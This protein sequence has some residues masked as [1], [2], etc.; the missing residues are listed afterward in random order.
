MS[1]PRKLQTLIVEDETDAVQAYK[2][3]FKNLA[4]SLPVAEPAIARSFAE[5]KKAIE[6][7]RIYHLVIVDLN[8]P[9]E[10]R[11]AAPDGFDLGAQLIELLATREAYPVPA[12]IVA[13][14]KLNLQLATLPIEKKLERDFLYGRKVSKGPD[15]H[16]AIE[17]AV[18]QVLRYVE[19]GIHIRESAGAQY[20]MITP[21][22]DY[23]LRKCVAAQPHVIGLDVR[24][25]G[26]EPGRSIGPSGP[27]PNRGP[28]KV[29]MG[30]FLLDG[31]GVSIPT[32]FKLE[33]G[34]NASS[35]SRD[36]S[37]LAQKLGHVKV[38]H[39]E[40]SR[41]RSLIVTQSVTNQGTPVPLDEYLRG[42]RV[43]AHLPKLV[44]QIAEQLG[45][46]GEKSDDEIALSDVLFEY[47]DRTAI[48]KVLRAPENRLAV[49]PTVDPL[50]LFDAIKA[51]VQRRWAAKIEC[52]HGDLNATNVA[53]DAGA[54]E[55]P[56]AY[57]FDGA[58]VKP[59]LDSRDLATL[60][61]T[62]I[63]FN[64]VGVDDDF[65]K[66]CA[67]LYA[68]TFVPKE[69]GGR[70]STFTRNVCSFVR[71]IRLTMKS[72]QQQSMYALMA[73]DA[74]LRQ[75][76]GLGLQPSPNKV[77]NPQHAC[78]LASWIAGWLARVAPEILEDNRTASEA[79]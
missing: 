50:E 5:A 17:E 4:K 37:I 62:T 74:A 65:F 11:Q 28:T 69:L 13:S 25:W 23:L 19:V 32:F 47:L 73:F 18:H 38:I 51:S 76:S 24:W 14:G 61:V 26:F 21:R 46:L 7:E 39:R 71:T 33:P 58:G 48:E 45:A 43:D 67:Q 70:P 2:V 55:N 54:E 77:R 8:L 20:G 42:D 60:E 79:T 68:T 3:I 75:L 56:Q 59:D 57:I 34:G 31:M 66:D 16:A 64:S 1:Y 22:E 29:L 72:E 9:H 78:M 44:D 53:I 10:A 30:R 49:E 52:N 40:E 27:S 15:Q 41:Q 36:A 12:V 63:L 35:V 6:A